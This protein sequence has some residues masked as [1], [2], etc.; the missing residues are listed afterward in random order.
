MVV[1]LTEFVHV[2]VTVAGQPACPVPHGRRRRSRRPVRGGTA[3]RS[4]AVN[5]HRT[6]LHIPYI[7]RSACAW[8]RVSQRVCGS[9]RLS[10]VQARR[11]ARGRVPARVGQRHKF[12]YTSMNISPSLSEVYNT[13]P[14][15]C[16]HIKNLEQNMCLRDASVIDNINKESLPQESG[17][18]PDVNC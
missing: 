15:S 3:Q 1:C 10:S 8:R 7:R 16:S 9:A 4:A 14:P 13:A 6:A 18:A 2:I 12:C 17:H 11:V 5:A